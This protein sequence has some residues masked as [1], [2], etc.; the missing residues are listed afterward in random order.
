MTDLDRRRLLQLG[1][2]AGSC[3][4]Q[5]R[6]QAEAQLQ[7]TPAPIAEYASDGLW[8][9][10]PARVWTEALPVGN[11]RIGAMLFG[12]IVEDRLQLNEDTLW[13]G[14][15]YDPVNPAARDALPRVR[16]L[17]NEQRYADAEA[18]ANDA[19]MATP[20]RQMNYQ[21]VGDLL[22]RFNGIE[23][24]DC[25]D[26]VRELDLATATHHLRFRHKGARYSRSVMASAVDQVILVQLDTDAAAGLDID[27]AL[28]SP[29]PDLALRTHAH[30][31]RLTGRNQSRQG[32]D[33][34]LRFCAG[35]AVRIDGGRQIAAS[36]QWSI[37][38]AR[39]VSLL[40]AMATSYRRFDDVGAD[41]VATVDA[42]LAAALTKTDAA[43]IAAQQADYR[44]LFDR[45]AIDLGGPDRRS[46]PTDARV[47]PVIHP[48]KSP[49]AADPGLAALYFR[50]A[51][52]LLIG[53]SRAG[54]QAANLQGIWN[55][56][57]DPP[58]G[59][60]YTI[61]INTEMNY[62][63]AEV[64]NLPECVEPLTRLVEDLAITGAVTA[65]G[66]YGARGWVCHHNTD[67]WRASAPI[68]GAF[69]GLWPTG[70]A[71]LCMALWDHWDYGRDPVYLKRIYPLLRG[72]AEFF[73]D[74]LVEEPGTGRLM[75]SPSI[76]PENRHPYGSTLCAG[77]TM[78]MQILRDLFGA[79]VEA[80]ALLDTDAGFARTLG[81]MR[82]R[83][84]PNRIGA[85]GQLQEWREDWDLDA[86][87]LQHR[88][89]SHL[90]GL[91]PGSQINLHD[92]PALAAAARR[93]L[94]IRSD[95]STGWAMGWRINL[96]ARLGDGE[97]AHQVLAQ[98]LGDQR[99]YPNLF[100]AH[101]PFQIDGNF[102]GTRG[103]CEMLLQDWG[104]TLRLLPALPPAWPQGSVRGLRARGAVEVDLAWSA[105]QLT[106]ARLRPQRDGRLDVVLGEQQLTLDVRRGESL[107]LGLDEGRLVRLPA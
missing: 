85:A 84:I 57:T 62:W 40:I 51:R 50:Y 23:A 27:L 59:S 49:L 48:V 17:I 6:A 61:N 5:A 107:R 99:T 36:P 3:P 86:P 77:P 80:A 11:G 60:K 31:L 73:V 70:G 25:S 39:R 10:Q 92:T 37:R 18:L 14:G 69:F 12:G 67:L 1:A 95:Q 97:H 29:M 94:K 20:L 38:G 81:T 56:Q 44:A 79:V 98:L 75:T 47:L 104:G 63:P 52:Y 82:E 32:I 89:V 103:I 16:A 90:Y 64:C 68:D 54:S 66:M 55:D 19:V 100:D 7:E 45:V 88:H 41:P 106:E 26:Y 83:L 74:T 42:Q 71:W 9:R 101:P 93:S 102:G 13:S 72:S 87:D 28:S 105:G 2:I 8:Y 96:W 78:D 91:F 35:L 53:C 34:A 24:A 33:A 65:R 58:W 30:G 21:T 46:T 43:L 76:S 15:P 22:L 4:L